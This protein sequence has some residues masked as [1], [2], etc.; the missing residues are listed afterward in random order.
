M[1]TINRNQLRTFGLFLGVV[2]A[3]CMLTAGVNAQA[4]FVGKVT[5]PY[6][7]HWG[8][9][10]LPP[11]DYSIRMESTKGMAKISSATRNVAVYTNLAT[12]ADNESGGTYLTI[13]SQGRE[14]RVRS[15]NLPEAGE[16]V[17]FAPLTKSEREYFAKSGQITTVPV[18]IAK[19]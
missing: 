19:K 12:I 18:I 4:S 17:I 6:E 15:L 13:T 1:K 10:V 16:L 7:V 3:S 9:A 14:R 5:L 11:G 2:L 8:Q